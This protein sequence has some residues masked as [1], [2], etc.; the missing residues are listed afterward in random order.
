MG[1][2]ILKNGGHLVRALREGGEEGGD[3]LVGVGRTGWWLEGFADGVDVVVEVEEVVL[4]SALGGLC[5]E[6]MN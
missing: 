3:G 6:E 2:Q 4:E 5:W 1:G